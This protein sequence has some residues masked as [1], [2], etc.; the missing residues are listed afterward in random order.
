MAI[1]S[2]QGWWHALSGAEQIY[3]GIALVASALFVIQLL[4]SFV[5]V[6]SDLDLDLDD[7]DAGIGIFS[8]K[9]LI[10]FFMFFGWGGIVALGA[11]LRT[12]Q[13]LMI[14]FLVG[15]LA[16][17]AVAYV[18][19]KLLGLQESGTVEIA[20]AVGQEAEVYLSIPGSKSGLG[21]I[22]LKVAGK[23]M[24]FD[25]V[26]TGHTLSYGASVIVKDIDSDNVMLVE[27]AT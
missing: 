16:M 8:I 17:V 20:G 3:W 21:K 9:G 6:D 4:L 27:A 5:G 11:G 26:T 2:V 24:E 12:P 23:I 18:F 19:S 13:V 14:A 15:F 10:S 7:G 1:L 22:H 25:A